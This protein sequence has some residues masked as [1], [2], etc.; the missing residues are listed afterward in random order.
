M[1]CDLIQELLASLFGASWGWAVIAGADGECPILCP[2]ADGVGLAF[3]FGANFQIVFPGM[4]VGR[5]YATHVEDKGAA[6]TIPQ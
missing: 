5:E 6:V 2:M 3:L 1:F 4:I